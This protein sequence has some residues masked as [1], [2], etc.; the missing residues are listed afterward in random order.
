MN[1][2]KARRI[3]Q[4]FFFVLFLWLCVVTTIGERWWQWRGWPVNW[5]L[6]LDPLVALGTLLTTCTL[7]AGLLWGVLTIALTILI[8]RFFCGWVCPFGALHQF[9][10]WIGRRRKK[11]AERVALNQFRPAQA[12]K[13]YL[14]IA[15]LSAAAGGLISEIIQLPHHQHTAA[16]WL[17]IAVL[18][19]L[20][21]LA[22]RKVVRTFKE[23]LIGFL[24]I[25]GAWIGIS[26][27]A[28]P[29]AFA[30]ASLQ[31]GLLDPI[32]LIHRSVNLVVLT[33]FDGSGAA[34]RFYVA[35]WSIALVFLLAL[36]LNLWIPR[37]YCRFICPLG[38]LFGVLVR[39]TPWRIGKRVG[40]CRSCE[41]CENNCEG[42][43]DP[44]GTIHTSEC[45]LC[46]N[47]LHA[48]RSAKMVYGPNRSASGEVEATGVT[49]R[50][51]VIA[52]GAGMAMV[53]AMR[54][55]GFL[56]HNWNSNVVRPPGALAEEDFL[57]RCIKCGQCMRVCPTNV[58]QPAL[59][60]AGLGG[61]WTPILNFRI[62]TSGCQLNCIA[63]GQIC[64]T[65]AIRP[66]ALE[67]KL[68]TN[69]FAAAGPIRMG[70]AFVDR[71]RCLPWAMDVPCIVCQENCPV[72]PKAIHLREEFQTIENGSR[73][74]RSASTT[75]LE[76]DGPPLR[77]S[78]LGTGDFFI[79]LES[80]PSTERKLITENSAS[81][82]SIAE[83]FAWPEAPEARQRVSIEVRL[84]KPMVDPER[85]IGC[86]VCQHE[87][88][89]SGLRGIR[90]TAENE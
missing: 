19:V 11:H 41:L 66:L 61:L 48:C 37:F 25:L 79:R 69:A 29:K 38:A 76:L 24:I 2:I 42:A 63:C 34:N 40:E 50:G 10:G 49:R 12:I 14:L 59:L 20:T 88:P 68:G 30:A 1:S 60:E 65:A 4:V 33:A 83:T 26:F 35:A 64:P 7:Y 36:L 16:S 17:L 52:A 70:T 81:S 53:P 67:E 58:I 43:C 82:V 51:F 84:Q 80:E 6:Q 85:C 74:I 75:R 78:K 56:D 47:C 55:G 72:S 89:V 87:C 32:P 3:A 5:F 21:W 28:Q 9:I 62:G 57:N 73:S 27:I 77:D 23:A 13:Y 22:L 15:L 71:G 18:L 44:F 45:L 39:W 54:L 86:G 90:V 8:G 46:M 31:T